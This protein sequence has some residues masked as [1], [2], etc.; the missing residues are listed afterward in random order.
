MYV[1]LPMRSWRRNI[2]VSRD[3]LGELAQIERKFPFH[4]KKILVPDVSLTRTKTAEFCGFHLLHCSQLL[5]DGLGRQLIIRKFRLV[6]NASSFYNFL[7]MILTVCNGTMIENSLALDLFRR[8]L[9]IRLVEEEIVTHYGQPGQPQEM[10]CPVHLSIGQEGVAA[11]V[12]AALES[13]D[14]VFSTHRCHAHYLA[15]VFFRE[16]AP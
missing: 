10:R 7:W 11:G 5:K 2:V 9:W 13:T 16:G 6:P 8:M 12:C 4:N 1:Y 3:S 15:K 14:V